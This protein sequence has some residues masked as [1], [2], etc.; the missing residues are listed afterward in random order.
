MKSSSLGNHFSVS[1]SV[2][3]K[4]SHTQ[5]HIKKNH[6]NAKTMQAAL[7]IIKLFRAKGQNLQE[8]LRVIIIG[9][10]KASLKI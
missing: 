6:I 8:Q 1:L 3:C 9:M 5:K 4:I 7:T 2:E 10:V